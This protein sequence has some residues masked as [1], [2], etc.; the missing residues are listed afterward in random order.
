M[1][2]GFKK[3]IL[4]GNVIDLAVGV[5][6]GAA[7]SGFVAALVKDLLTPLIAAI[8][9]A[10]DFSALTFTVNGSKFLYGDFFNVFIAFLVV[11]AAVYFFVVLPINAL[12]VKVG[13]EPA[14]APTIKTCPECASLINVK[15]KRCPFCTSTLIKEE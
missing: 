4:R 1:L 15:A 8:F 11:S 14:A 13:K 12:I 9:K 5:V 7:F 2:N 3:F 10:P 6:V